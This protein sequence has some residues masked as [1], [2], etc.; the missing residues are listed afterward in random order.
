MFALLP[1]CLCAVYIPNSHAMGSC[2]TNRRTDLV[3]S[4]SDLVGGWCPG[5]VTKASLQRRRQLS[6]R[7]LGQSGLNLKSFLRAGDAKNANCIICII[8]GSGTEVILK[9][10]THNYRTYC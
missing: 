6:D 7:F 9:P 4:P 8:K 5:H 3:G 10:R 2:K 1:A